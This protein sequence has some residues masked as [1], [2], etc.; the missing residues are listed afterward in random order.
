MFVCI[1][2]VV[3]SSIIYQLTRAHLSPARGCAHAVSSMLYT[4]TRNFLGSVD[5]DRAQ[6]GEPQVQLVGRGDDNETPNWACMD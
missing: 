5:V 1:V 6:L 2:L 3:Y 4:S